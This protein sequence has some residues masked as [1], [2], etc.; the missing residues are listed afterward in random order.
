[1]DVVNPVVRRWLQ[2]AAADPDAFWARAAGELPWFRRWDETFAWERP[3]FRWFSGGLTNISFNAVDHH[4]QH[5]RGGHAALVW[6]SERGERQVLTYAQLLAEVEATTAALRGLGVRRGDRVAVY[7]PTIPAAVVAMLAIARIGAI[8]LVVFAGFGSG[9]LAERI[10]LAGAKVLLTTDVTWRKGREIDLS[11]IAGEALADP[12]SPIERVVVL[13][14]GTGQ[15]DLQPGRDLTWDAFLAGGAGYSRAHEVMEANEPAF[16]LATS[17]TTAKPKLAVHS[18]GGYQVGIHSMGRWCFGMRPDDVWWAS[19]D[20][21]WIVGHSYMVYA[22]LLAGCTTIAYEGALDHPGPETFYRILAENRVTGLFTSPTAVR[23]L[24]AYGA[25]PAAG[26]GLASVERV[27]CAGEVLNP[28]AW[29]WLQ[30]EVFGDR[31]PVIDHM[32][33]TETG[34]PVFGNPYGIGLLPIKPGSS[35]IPLPGIFAEVRTVEG[36]PCPPGEK[37]IVVLTRPFPSLTPT[38]WGDPERYAREYWEKIPGVYFTGDAASVDDDGYF[39]FSGRAD[40]IIKIAGHRIGTI[41]VES[42]VLRHPSV[43]EVGVCGRPDELR[44]E[45]VSA[46]VVLRGGNQPSDELRRELIATVRQELGPVAVIGEINFVRMLPKTRSGKIMRRVFKAV[47]LDRDPGDIS[48]IEDA[49]SVEEARAAWQALRT[50]VA[51]RA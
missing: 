12:E 39:W 10:R 48:T 8:H 13:P 19:A 37:G 11:R 42:A 33:Q 20:V 16:V 51:G 26:F 3:T 21:G 4:V 50:E 1:M 5:G 2:D 30:R 23:M 27:F 47:V 35:G 28:P 32:W 36:E 34:G 25:A 45:V 31:V 49:G 46:F 44:G 7:L 17:G 41:E 18:H 6:H 22:P 38:I 15:P 43:A 9:A 24:M 29:A 14:R 40:E